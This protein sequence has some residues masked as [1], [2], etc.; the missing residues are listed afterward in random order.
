MGLHIG[1]YISGRHEVVY[2]YGS[3]K[4]FLAVFDTLNEARAVVRLLNKGLPS[5]E[6]PKALAARLRKNPESV[7]F[8]TRKEEYS[9]SQIE[10][11]NITN[12]CQIVFATYQIFS[13]G[14]DVPRLDMGVE[15][16]PSG[17]LKQPLGRILRLHD[18]KPEPEWYAICDTVELPELFG[19]A[20][21]PA[22]GL[23]NAFLSGK[24]KT[25]INA[26]KRA[27]A[28]LTYA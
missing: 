20:T 10:L 19:N 16:L 21:D 15:G 27:K 7:M 8:S 18:G 11:D 25:R 5:V 22:A 23:I 12:S 6:L 17:N 24:T 28:K 4:Q 26:L 3:N 13:K 9:P 14:V 2:S 1:T